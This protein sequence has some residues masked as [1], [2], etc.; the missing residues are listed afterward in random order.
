[1][2]KRRKERGQGLLELA[3]IL[4]VLLI[5][6]MG[7]VELGYALRDYLVVVNA[8]REGCR[9]AARGRYSDEDIIE[10]TIS[11]GGIVRQ[12]DPP[13][14]VPFLRTAS[15]GGIDSNT[16]VIVTNIPTDSFGEPISVTVTAAGVVPV[17][18]V[19]VRPAEPLDTLVSAGQIVD[20]HRPVTQDIN[21][22]R[23]VEGYE[24]MGN[25][26]VVVEVFFM[27]HPLWNNPF[28]PLPDP[29]N[30]HARTEMRV[31][32]DRETVE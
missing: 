23:E 5:L 12:G 10:R 15:I 32:T 16:A 30:M 4:P 3:V 28:V 31:V 8:S 27:H 11:A 13:V 7:L 22:A 29:M 1:M 18:E 19:G 14:D 21:A 6:L 2:G 9:F 24:R 25:H 26:I 17:G 20:R